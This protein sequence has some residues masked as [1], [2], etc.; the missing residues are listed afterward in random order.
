MT[1]EQV[2]TSFALSLVHLFVGLISSVLSVFFG[3]NL[4]NKMTGELDEWKEL[5]K[6]NIAV[7]TMFVGVIISVLVMIA[8]T[9]FSSINAIEKFKPVSSFFFFLI[10]ALIN[11]FLAVLFSVLA[12]Y[13]S[14]QVADKLTFDI[15]ELAELRKGNVAVALMISAI[16]IGTA[17][18]V[19]GFI[20][21]MV[22]AINLF[23]LIK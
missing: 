22:D 15:Q 19:T 7:G 10:V 9:A 21:Q 4:L 8:P 5:K 11:V 18:L 16:L 17:F 3:L 2:A 14:I 1:A 12:L 20:T 23:S 6:G 13:I